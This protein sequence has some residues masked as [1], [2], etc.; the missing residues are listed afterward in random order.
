M[1]AMAWLPDRWGKPLGFE[2]TLIERWIGAH[3]AANHNYRDEANEELGSKRLSSS[4][5]SKASKGNGFNSFLLFAS[6][7]QKLGR[8][9]LRQ[10]NDAQL[11]TWKFDR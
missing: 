11:G 6:D 10:A 7:H 5:M 1:D 8:A 2:K 3:W 4:S 9:Q